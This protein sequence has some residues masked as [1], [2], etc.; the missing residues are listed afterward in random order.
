MLVRAPPLT[1]AS[2]RANEEFFGTQ[3]FLDN[4]VVSEET[5]LNFILQMS[6]ATVE[7]R[8]VLTIRMPEDENNLGYRF[9]SGRAFCDIQSPLSVRSCNIESYYEA[10]MSFRVTSSAAQ[11]EKK[12]EGS[13]SYFKNPDS[14]QEITGIQFELA[15]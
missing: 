4:K 10:S 1:L 6:T 8:D 14:T 7:D 2:V 9:V 3:V 12:L 5:T 11:N 13:L 15:D